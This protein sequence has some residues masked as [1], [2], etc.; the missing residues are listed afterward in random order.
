VHSRC[1][2]SRTL[3]SCPWDRLSEVSQLLRKD[4]GKRAMAQFLAQVLRATRPLAAS[5]HRHGGERGLHLPSGSLIVGLRHLYQWLRRLLKRRCK[6]VVS[7]TRRCIARRP[8]AESECPHQTRSTFST[9]GQALSWLQVPRSRVQARK[10]AS[11]TRPAWF[12]PRQWPAW[13]ASAQRCPVEELWPVQQVLRAC[14]SYKASTHAGYL[15]LKGSHHQRRWG[16][17]SQVA[18]E[19]WRRLR[20]LQVKHS[21]ARNP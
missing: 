13:T 10:S 17:S 6:L 2:T 21:A 1:G 16:H 7:T 20:S 5:P 4:R 18:G 11:Q 14:W 8:S 9:L 15:D 3:R 12:V 19:C